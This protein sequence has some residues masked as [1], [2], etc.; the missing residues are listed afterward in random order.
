MSDTRTV[1]QRITDLETV[2]R[3]LI[4]FNGNAI[5]TLGR[6]VSEGNPAIA[7][8]IARDL[9]ALKS[10][11]YSGIDKELHDHYVD[12]LIVSITGKA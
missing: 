8:V 7:D 5:A 3:T 10:E 6:R 11:S 2:L 12:N 4:I 1:D 9:A